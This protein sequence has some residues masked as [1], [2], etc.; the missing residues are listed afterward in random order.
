[1]FLNEYKKCVIPFLPLLINLIMRDLLTDRETAKLLR[2]KI[3]SLY[4]T[5]DFFDEFDDDEW[6]LIEGEHFEY[7]QRHG[8]LKERRFTEEGVEALAKYLEGDQQGLFSKVLESLTQRKRKRKQLLVSRR[9]TQE[10]IDG[11][12][13]VEAVGNLLFVDRKTSINILQTNGLGINNA[14]KRLAKADSLDGQESLEID[15]HFIV[16][17]DGSHAWSQ[18]G[19][20]SIA[21]DMNQHSRITK[22]RRAWVAAVG[23]VI[24]DCF[25]KEVKRLE[26]APT[27][28]TNAISKAKRASN[29][30]CQVTG[31]SKARGKILELDGH[32]L[33][34]KSTRPDLADLHENILVMQSSIHDDFH[35][36]KRGNKCVPSD[37]L[38]YLNEAR[39]DLIDPVNSRAEARYEKLLRKL[40]KLQVNYEGNKLRYA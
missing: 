22:A 1:M 21:L 39:L 40:H 38:D 17:E 28:I 26:S 14:I 18:K 7:V 6:D 11:D 37:F 15:H 19:I 25:K 34:D 36:W 35:S 31:S 5:V 8:E 33:F 13:L 30:T 12:G 20:A 10:L 24:E 3:N 32:H 29:N 23:E 4:K 2:I 27:R 16:A 9:I